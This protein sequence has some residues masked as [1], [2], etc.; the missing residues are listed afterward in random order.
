M[1]A[2]GFGCLIVGVVSGVLLLKAAGTQPY[3]VLS[4]LLLCAGV[5]SLVRWNGFRG[6]TYYECQSCGYRWARRYED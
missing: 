1:L 2:F 3:F 6:R 5:V 4:L